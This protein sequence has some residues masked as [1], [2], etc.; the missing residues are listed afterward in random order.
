MGRVLDIY[1]F[2]FI[3]INSYIYICRNCMIMYVCQCIYIYYTFISVKITGHIDGYTW[4][5]EARASRRAGAGLFRE[6]AACRAS[7]NNWK[8][9]KWNHQWILGNHQEM[10]MKS[11]D[12]LEQTWENVAF[13]WNKHE[14]M[15]ILIGAYMRKWWFWFLMMVRERQRELKQQMGLLVAGMEDRRGKQ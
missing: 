9:P 4:R 11:H 5:S 7:S 1:Q 6:I 15:I 10:T 3:Y 13:D 14:T 8:L 2:I 12:S